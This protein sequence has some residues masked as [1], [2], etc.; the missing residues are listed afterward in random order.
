MTSQTNSRFPVRLPPLVSGAQIDERLAGRL[1]GW[2]DDESACDATQGN[3][4][5]LKGDSGGR[6]DRT[7]FPTVRR[8]CFAKG[9]P[10]TGE[11]AEEE[12]EAHVT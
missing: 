6:E 1:V 12:E 9:C 2:L 11:E 4:H 10:T 5:F 7:G 3:L 8:H